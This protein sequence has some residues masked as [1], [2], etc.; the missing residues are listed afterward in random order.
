VFEHFKGK[1]KVVSVRLARYG[2]NKEL[3][4]SAFVEF[5]TAAEMEKAVEEYNAEAKGKEGSG[6]E[7]KLAYN[8]RKK[9]EFDERTAQR[10]G[11]GGAAGKR[12]RDDDA[13]AAAGAAAAGAEGESPVKRK[14]E[15]VLV[16]GVSLKLTGLPDNASRED[17]RAAYGAHGEIAFIDFSRGEK[18]GVVQFANAADAAKAAKA[19]ADEATRAKVCGAAVASVKLLEGEEE[20]KYLAA[21]KEAASESKSRNGGGRGGFRGGR[22]GRG[23][24]RGRGGRRN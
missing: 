17:I 23:G 21:R 24:G 4:G 2:N 15:S 6:A 7:T 12:K 1:G 11:K 13:G 10:E 20:E 18:D 3:K 19:E 8:A 16:P 9:K 5:E 22:G 14:A